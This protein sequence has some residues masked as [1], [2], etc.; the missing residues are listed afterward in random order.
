[1]TESEFQ[2]AVIDLA[3]LS[4]WRVAH[5][6]AARTAHGWRTPTSADAAGFP[7]LVLVH[8]ERRQVLYRELKSERGRLTFE[9]AEWRRTL[10][11][12]GQD[13]ALWRPSDWSSI[14]A[15]L[16]FGSVTP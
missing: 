13:W 14:V 5:F 12:A 11:A 2:G 4:G 3:H 6:R 1:M 16:S 7:D 8:A 10:T 15:R 9:Q